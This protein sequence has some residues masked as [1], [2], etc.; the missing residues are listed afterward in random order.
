MRYTD[1][2]IVDG[3]LDGSTAVAM[4]DRAGVSALMIDPHPIYPPEFRS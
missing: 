3:V 4:L 1:V 2:A